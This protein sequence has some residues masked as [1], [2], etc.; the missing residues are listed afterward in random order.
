VEGV[1]CDLCIHEGGVAAGGVDGGLVAAED[2]LED[3]D[4]LV[5]CVADAG[6]EAFD[7][8]E[9]GFVR[10]GAQKN[11]LVGSEGEGQGTFLDEAVEGSVPKSRWHFEEVLHEAVLV[12]A[13]DGMSGA[14]A[15]FQEMEQATG[16]TGGFSEIALGDVVHGLLEVVGHLG[17][18]VGPAV[19]LVREWIAV[20][21]ECEAAEGFALGGCAHE[22]GDHAIELDELGAL[23]GEEMLLPLGK[24]IESGLGDGGVHGAPRVGTGGCEQQDERGEQA[25]ECAEA[26]REVRHGSGRVSPKM[27]WFGSKATKITESH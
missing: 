26:V 24:G 7:E 19:R 10:G 4:E 21:Q 18:V 2:A 3:G 22:V 9:D 12:V 25:E 16:V 14:S 23:I 20:G 15:V 5:A 17:G 8:V 27:G 13:G 1:G 11:G 6:V